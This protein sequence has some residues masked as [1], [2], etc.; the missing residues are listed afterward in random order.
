VLPPD[1]PFVPELDSTSP[2]G[3]PADATPLDGG[4]SV[5]LAPRSLLLLRTP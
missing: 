5:L 1:G 2:D 4:K 3:A